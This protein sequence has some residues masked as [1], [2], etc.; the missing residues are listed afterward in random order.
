MTINPLAAA[1][2]TSDTSAS[3]TGINALGPDSFLKLLIA[4]LQNQDPESP[5]DTGQMVTQLAQMEMVSEN[6]STRQ[7]QEMSQALDLMGHT[8]QWQD[9]AS[10]QLYQGKVSAVQKDGTEARIVV[11]STV[12]KLDAILTVS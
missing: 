9:Q 5:M 4:Q 1:V 10:G 7:S 8:V 11:G 12:L 3:S 2:Q 6:R